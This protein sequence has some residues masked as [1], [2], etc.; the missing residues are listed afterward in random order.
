MLDDILSKQELKFFRSLNTPKKI[1][2]FL[3]TIRINF[4]E[5]GETVLSPRTVLKKNICHCTEGAILAALMLRV[6]GYPPLLVD[7]AATKDDFD[8]V[9]A[10][11]KKNGKWGAISKTNHA[12]LRYREPIYNSIR[13][14]A[15]TFFHE[16][17]DDRGKKNLRSYSLPVNLKRFDRRGWMTTTEEVDYIPEYL[18]DAKHYPMLNRKQISNLRRADKVEIQAGKIVEWQGKKKTN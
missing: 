2:S 8:H 7:L 16:Y 9:L 15:M 5:D 13:E 17:F 10:V 6:N 3:D 11:F 12:V 14:L 18:A 1:Q 4:E